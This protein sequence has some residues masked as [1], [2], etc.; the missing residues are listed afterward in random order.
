[1]VHGTLRAENSTLTGAGFAVVGDYGSA[2]IK[3]EQKK[4]FTQML[5][6]LKAH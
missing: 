3:D 5:D 1:M 4:A 2:K 6:W